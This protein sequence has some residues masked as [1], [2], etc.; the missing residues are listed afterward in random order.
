MITADVLPTTT[1]LLQT[2]DFPGGMPGEIGVTLCW[3]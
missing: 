2:V 3:P 1:D